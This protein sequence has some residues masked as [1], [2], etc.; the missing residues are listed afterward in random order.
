MER[1]RSFIAIELPQEI[2]AELTSLEEKLKVGKHPGV[3]WVDPVGIHLT[4]KFLGGVTPDKITE[5]VEAISRVAQDASPLTLEIGELGTFPSWQ[6]PQVVWVGLTGEISKLAALQKNV[7]TAL[8]PLGFSP[9]SRS[10]TA[11]LTL[12]RLR[13]SVPTQERQRFGQLVASTRFEPSHA[14]EVDALSL[15]KSQL[16]PTGAIYS[17]LASIK[18]GRTK[19][20]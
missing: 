1:I 17:R 13:E 4:L 12:A 14:F 19:Q 5:I 11:H 3:K 16:T 18:L 8:V 15:M 20:E 6:R 2:K 7:D 10:F 9:E